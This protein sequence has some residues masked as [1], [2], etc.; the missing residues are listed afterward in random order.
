MNK[1]HSSH[2]ETISSSGKVN[3]KVS[4]SLQVKQLH[5][6]D[7]MLMHGNKK[8][9]E[10][11]C[12]LDWKTKSLHSAHRLHLTAPGIKPN[13]L[14]M[15]EDADLQRAAARS[16]LKSRNIEENLKKNI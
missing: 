10:M 3:R 9:I 13:K 1:Q 5:T 2:N 7:H 14:M 8:T 15:S 6:A 16:L 11:S 12:E 4:A